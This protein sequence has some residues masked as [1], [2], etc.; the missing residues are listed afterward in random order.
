MP[1][2]TDW[3]GRRCVPNARLGSPQPGRHPAAQAQHV[4]LPGHTSPRRSST[5][6]R[7]DPRSARR[8][9]LE[10]QIAD[11]FDDH[12]QAAIVQ[13]M[14]GFGPILAA[15]LLVTAG[16]LRAFPSG[17]HLAVAAGPSV[18]EPQRLSTRI[19]QPAPTPLQPAPAPRVL[20]VRANQHDARRTPTA[21]CRAV[22]QWSRRGASALNWGFG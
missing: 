1:G 19:G 11:S 4:V 2:V 14:P 16:D 15:T 12:D 9:D 20:P 18:P 7:L 6:S 3:L 17:G 10:A 8:Q 21:I 13:S 5:N 22:A